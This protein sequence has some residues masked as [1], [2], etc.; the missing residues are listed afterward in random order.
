MPMP[1]TH[2]HTHTH[3]QFWPLPLCSALRKI[4]LTGYKIGRT[5]AQTGITRSAYWLGICSEVCV[6]VLFMSQYSLSLS[7]I[8]TFTLQHAQVS[9]MQQDGVLCGEGSVHSDSDGTPYCIPCYTDIFGP[10]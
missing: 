5:S 10:K 6:L 7:E 2:T 4:F 9:P 3:T 8:N 1:H